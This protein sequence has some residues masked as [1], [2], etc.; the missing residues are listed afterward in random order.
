MLRQRELLLHKRRTTAVAVGVVA[1]LLASGTPANAVSDRAATAIARLKAS[2]GPA[3]KG[4]HALPAKSR[5]KMSDAAARK[6]V[7]KAISWPP[8]AVESLT[9][10]PAS[11]G[12]KS[13]AKAVGKAT[14]VWLQAESPSR[15]SDSAPMVVKVRTLDRAAA[16]AAGV[17][18]VL[19]TLD[20][21]TIGVGT[22]RVGVD[23]RTFAE[24]YGGN[25]G[26]RLRL[27]QL[28]NCALT[29][30]AVAACRR[31]TPLAS[32]NDLGGR[33]V[34]ARVTLPG[35][36]R[37]D[38]SRSAS[39]GGGMIVL[40][41]QTDPGN[42]GGSG[43]TYAA[44]DLSPSGS[45]TGGGSTGAFTHSYPIGVP[46]ASS[47]LVPDVDLS[48]N[49]SETDGRTAS[50]QAQASWAGE[51]WSTPRSYI[52]QSFASCAD[53]PEGSPSPVSTYDQCYN[54]PVLTMSLN[55][56]STSLVW[57]STKSAWRSKNDSGD[58]IT[59]VM[60][61]NNGSGTRDTD[62]WTVKTRDGSVFEFGR[63]RL[64]GW[65]T[66]KAATNSVDYVPV[67]SSHSGDPCYDSAGFSRSVCKMAYRWNLDYVKDLRGNAM[68][69]Y[70]KQNVNYYGQNKGADNV[71][72]IRDSYLD[73]IDYGFTDG[74]AYGT[75]PNKVEFTA[76]DRCVS[77]TCQPLNAANKAN[78]PDVPY[79]LVCVSG[80][81]CN[82]WSPSY[83]STVRLTSIMTKQ[84]SPAAAQYLPVDYYTLTQTIP[85]TGDG[86]SPTLWL[87][88]LT[89]TGCA[90]V[91]TVALCESGSG[92]AIKL[93]PMQFEAVK[94]PNRVDAVTDGMP[95]FFKNRIA[96][97]T[98]EAGSVIS[99]DYDR[100]NPCTAPVALTP[101]TNTKSCYPVRWT[102]IGYKDPLKE[103]WFHKYAVTKV[104]ATDPTG[105][106]V[107]LVTSYVYSGGAAWHFDDNEAI[108]AKYRSYGQYRGYGK[109]QTLTGDGVND[110]QTLSESTFYRGMS[111][112][113]NTTVVNVTDSQG[114]AHE[115]LDELAG[116]ELESTSYLG[117]GGPVDHSTVT[118]YW[119]SAPTATRNRTG[120]SALTARWVA[121]AETFTRQALTATGTTTW[122]VTETDNTYDAS[123]TSPTIG[124]LQRSYTHTVP[125]D[126][127][128]DQ[129]VTNTYAPVNTA[130]NIVGLIAE[131]EKVSVKCG[132]FTQ[133][134]PA[135]V[136]NG[137]N[138]LTAPAPNRPAQV[139]SDEL[140]FYD[141]NGW[142]TTF[143]Q[144]SAPTKGDVTMTRQASDYTNG[145]YTFQT[146]GRSTYDNYGRV[147]DTYD[148]NGNKTATLYTV[149]S[150]G[151]TTGMSVTKPLT[152]SSKK[153]LD[154][155]NGGVLT[156]TDANGVTTTQQYDMLGRATKIWVASRPTSTPANYVFTYAISNTGITAVTTQK[157]NE[158]LGYQT[159]TVI[160][161][162]LL[163]KR[164]TQS[165]TPQSGRMVTDTFYD[166]RGWTRATYNGWWDSATSPNT[167]LIGAADL[168]RQVPNQSFY[169]YDGLGRAVYER[170]A[171]NG[172]IKSTTTTVY[173]GDRT[174]VI[175]PEGGAAQTTITDPLGRTTELDQYKAIPTVTVPTNT[176]TGTFT[177]TGGTKVP[178]TYGYDGHGRQS[179]VTD[180][181]QASWTTTFNLLGQPTSKA[182]PDAGTT[183]IKYDG[184]GNLIETTDSRNKKVS[185]T[186]DQLNRKTGQ[187]AAAAN[188]QTTSNRLASW[189]YDNSDNVTGVTNPY[190][191]R[192][193]S[194]AYWGGA[195]YTVREKGFDAFGNPLGST[196]TI[197][198]TEGS[199]LGTTYTVTHTYSPNTGLLLK[200]T[201][202]LK[203]G[204]PMET[205]NH[206][207][208]GGV[209]DLPSTL[210]G[211]AGYSDLTTYD[212]W[213]R[214][215]QQTVG[216][217]PNVTD[218]TYAYDEHTGRLKNR[219]VTRGSTSYDEQDYTHDLAGNITR[220]TS[221]RLGSP[222][223]AE[224]QCFDY[225]TL[226]R[227]TEAWTAT[228]NCAAT[229]TPTNSSMVGDNLGAASAYWTTW[230]IDDLGNRSQQIQHTSGTD[231]TTNYTYNG[232]GANQ[233]HTLTATTSTNGGPGS[234]YRY[235][236][237]GNMTTRNAG[238]GNQTLTWDDAGRLTRIAGSTGGDSDFIYDADGNLLLQKDPGATILYLPGQQITLNTTTNTATAIRYYP[239]PGGG[240]AVRTGSSTNYKFTLADPHETSNLVLDNTAQNPT[241][242]QF[243]PYG[244]PRGTTNTWVDNRQF[245]NK[246]AN[247]N[248]ALTAVGAR[249]Y[250]PNLGRFISI[251][252]EFHA[253]EP[254][255][256]NGYS[257]ANNNPNTFSDPSG[258]HNKEGG[259]GYCDPKCQAAIDDYNKKDKEKK[260]KETKA[261]GEDA[262]FCASAKYGVPCSNKSGV[263][264]AEEQVRAFTKEHRGTIATVAAFVGCLVPGVGWALCTVFQAA[265]FGVRTEQRI[266]DGGGWEKNK[267]DIGLDLALTIGTAGLSGVGHLARVGNTQMWFNGFKDAGGFKPLV[268]TSEWTQ[269]LGGGGK[270]LA[271]STG[272]W[273]ILLGI[274]PV[275]GYVFLGQEANK[276]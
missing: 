38:A 4:V 17:S 7:P 109:V 101:S 58:V 96:R 267:G 132:G 187:Y 43:G 178:T 121:P 217:S 181:S 213:G 18:G 133:G 80:A 153:T 182:D 103:D 19:L 3:V 60:N 52:E 125:A 250:D 263:S 211:L 50:T 254:Q 194:T 63:N 226:V 118:S 240:T 179:T 47:S 142:S 33:S 66:D 91:A 258:R 95:A 12:G 45:W 114:G 129:C 260:E 99:V 176:F 92:G 56:S 87:T 85:A 75:V 206:G 130:K 116:R 22:A 224:T 155:R 28:P 188:A 157:M 123:L 53:S 199:V 119:L 192:T 159:N 266:S 242:R 215:N 25:Y 106:A 271:L 44:T 46:P 223:T 108:K 138:T 239:L 145:A 79:D 241:W 9:V 165:V 32:T 34:S 184:N 105:G 218:V 231:T 5:P 154:P 11:A 88:S 255:T 180:T 158:L 35:S 198:S 208:D 212:A 110:A 248:T 13:G 264:D 162:A 247:T 90:G 14:P 196:V 205:V 167:T 252:P 245:L 149:N 244:A 256:L 169:T 246:P 164:Q 237:A 195:A 272:D 100:P 26:S 201:Y 262:K 82:S 144:T 219:K 150:V 143:P 81:T 151:L 148:G 51:G 232:N 70:Y 207:Y 234:T 27:V 221:T 16:E 74:N 21:G 20:T 117:N 140:T 98:T 174:T 200:D 137:L 275:N 189:V 64:P 135:S 126:P 23:Y 233:P 238:Q 220:Q 183:S 163:R 203:W 71:P 202:P 68:A 152:P 134:T 209:L 265:A 72:Y 113:N 24:A 190:G 73:H 89:H 49:S 186:Y 270:F 193:S 59:H 8:G 259:D 65:A 76:G 115:D 141:D 36:A 136:P 29:T 261:K 57:D 170:R 84:Y 15:G 37:A 225:D 48:Y 78:W 120:L 227:L 228:D 173:N 214:V 6:Y 185:Y 39:S 222:S 172:V 269:G 236:T 171:H 61:S 175:P 235:D 94:L 276:G 62:Y 161:D 204:L 268:P 2:N 131:V 216:A 83:F 124:L 168:G 146:T 77:G 274:K 54:G 191:R 197:P 147:L 243:T 251:D 102:P 69:Y 40:A 210:G 122:R 86:T 273:V 127:K 10:A 55:G 229:P 257:Y 112:N 41:T 107:S 128:Y 67:F 111:K 31:R 139:I 104:T 42:E 249:N 253:D 97:I 160:Y 156:D 30:P 93:P 177:I 1:V 230:T 166:S